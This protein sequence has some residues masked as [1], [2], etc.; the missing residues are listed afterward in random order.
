MQLT[1]RFWWYD[2]IPVNSD[3]PRKEAVSISGIRVV[4]FICLLVLCSWTL[5]Q[6]LRMNMRTDA[7]STALRRLIAE[8]M[9]RGRSSCEV[10]F[11]LSVQ[12]LAKDQDHTKQPVV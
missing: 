9:L 12:S 1:G 10:R 3:L 2:I 7:W 11:L 4:P 8:G 5:R 6:G